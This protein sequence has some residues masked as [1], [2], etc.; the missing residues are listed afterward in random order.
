VHDTLKAIIINGGSAMSTSTASTHVTAKRTPY[1]NNPFFIAIEGLKLFFTKAVG[2]A[3]ILIIVSAFFQASNSGLSGSEPARQS[4]T[5]SQS[6]SSDAAISSNVVAVIV[7][8]AVVIGTGVV[9][10]VITVGT[11]LAGITAYSS[12][13]LANGKEASLSNAWK[14]TTDQFWSLL[15]LQ[16]LTFI[17]IFAWS[18]L[19]IVPGIVMALRYSL[20]NTAFFDK[21]LKGNAALKESLALTKGSWITLFGAQTVFSIVTLGIINN[22][23]SASTTTIL[24]RQFRDTPLENRPKAHGLSIA[25]FV[26]AIVVIALG[27]IAAVALAIIAAMHG[28]TLNF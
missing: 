1:I 21:G 26:V 14:A 4:T 13:Q 3:V 9:I 8:L 6:T 18:L 27:I 16:V 7:V 25:A 20:A 17:K 12:A 5:S 15:W 24:Y 22:L 11:L 10:A 2:I 19:F 23:T 28:G